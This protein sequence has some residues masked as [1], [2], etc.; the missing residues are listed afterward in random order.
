MLQARVIWCLSGLGC[1]MEKQA[2]FRRADAGTSPVLVVS[3]E[4]DTA[5]SD[6]DVVTVL[7][8][9]AGG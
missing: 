5:V 3:G 8:A 7:P 4:I 9:V 1:A 2:E 6:G